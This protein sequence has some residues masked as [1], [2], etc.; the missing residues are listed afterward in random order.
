MS[1]FAV[2]HLLPLLV[3]LGSFTQA[4]SAFAEQPQ[5]PSGIVLKHIQPKMLPPA[6]SEMS[7]E[8]ELSN[9]TDAFRPLRLYAVR[10][11]RP[12][13]QTIREAT[14]N[15]KEKPIYSFTLTAPIAEIRYQFFLGDAPSPAASKPTTISSAVETPSYTLSRPCVPLS[16]RHNITLNENAVEEIRVESQ[17]IKPLIIRSQAIE[18]EAL[19]LVQAHKSLDGILQLTSS[20]PASKGT[21]NE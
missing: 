2:Q 4:P 1:R 16:I 3:L 11:G 13:E 6:G 9:P 17:E 15:N 20:A 10:D 14:Y 5:A 18:E 21:T 12:Y 8:V 19:A 7:F